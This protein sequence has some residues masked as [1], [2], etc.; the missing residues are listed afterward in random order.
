[1]RPLVFIFDKQANRGSKGDAMLESRL[2]MYKILFVSGSGEIALAWSSA[3]KL[4]LDISGR[5]L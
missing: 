4:D 1:V 2:Q 5:E 3:A